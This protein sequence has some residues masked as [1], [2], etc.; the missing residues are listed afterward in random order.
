MFQHTATRRWLAAD[1]ATV[2]SDTSFQH[3]ATRRW[4]VSAAVPPLHL[5]DVSTHSHPK[6]AGCFTSWISH[7]PLM[8]QHTATRRWLGLSDLFNYRDSGFQ[9][10]AT[11][12]WLGQKLSGRNATRPVSTHSHPKVAGKHAPAQVWATTVSTHSHPK[13]AG[14]VRLYIKTLGQS[15]NTQPPE[16]GWPRMLAAE[17]QVKA[18][19]THSHPKVAGRRRRFQR[20]DYQVSTHSHPKVAGCGGVLSSR[21]CS[22][23]N[24]QPPEGGWQKT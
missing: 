5:T 20:S 9:H 17:Q 21:A 6:V 14:C 13:V 16:G 22:R 12:R 8:F 4:L 23:F 18:V 3:T 7:S 11:R 15:F 10:T 24:T 2:R 19:S 1:T